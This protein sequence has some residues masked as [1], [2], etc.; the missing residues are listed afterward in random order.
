M[1]AFYALALLVVLL[2]TVLNL[3]GALHLNPILLHFYEPHKVLFLTMVFLMLG[4]LARVIIFY[5]QILWREAIPL[6]LW[7]LI[8]GFTGGYFVGTVPQKIIVLLFFVSGLMYLAK[9]IFKK[10]NTSP[11]AHGVFVAGVVTAF[12]Q[13][14]GI[15]AGAIRQGYLASRGH[16]LPTIHGTAGFSFI[17][18]SIATISARIIHEDFDVRDVLPLITFFPFM[19]ATV[20]LGKKIIYKMP[21]K[22]Q[23][24]III[25]SL[26]LSL[27]FAV[28][29]LFK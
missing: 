7:A 29:Y 19:I 22:V 11:S 28:P 3:P 5:K 1:F 20:Y 6:A 14:F 16:D 8:G 2:G 4:A 23:D 13:A 27:L 10:E 15:S 25:Y 24:A 21:K 18:G 17:I 12:L 9:T 26:I